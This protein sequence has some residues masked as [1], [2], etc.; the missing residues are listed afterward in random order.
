MTVAVGQRPTRKLT[1]S[2][3]GTCMGAAPLGIGALYEFPM[4]HLAEEAAVDV[5]LVGDSLGMVVLGHNSMVPVA[6]DATGRHTR[7]VV[8]GAPKIHVIADMPFLTNHVDDGGTS[9]GGGRL[10][11]EEGADPVKLE[12]RRTV[13]RRI[14]APVDAGIPVC[15]H[16]GVT[17]EGG[18][19][20]G[21]LRVEGAAAGRAPHVSED[22]EAVAEAEADALIL[23]AITAEPAVPVSE[24]VSMPTIGIGAGANRD[25]QELLTDDLVRIEE[26]FAPQFVKRSVDLAGVMRGAYAYAEG[27]RQPAPGAGAY[28]PSR[29]RGGPGSRRDAKRM[30]QGAPPAVTVVAEQREALDGQVPGLVPLAGA[31]HEGHASLTSGSAA[32]NSAT[33]VTVF[34]NPAQFAD[35]D[36]FARYPKSLELHTTGTSIHGATSFFS[37]AVEKMDPTEP[38]SGARSPVAAEVDG[39][40]L[41]DNFEL[42][43]GVAG[44]AS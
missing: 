25:G 30:G 21:V 12:G 17:P 8:R 29:S 24:R 4:V 32:E 43:S 3:V 2:A 44:W 6:L 36:A 22:A 38:I 13:V 9:E 23:E 26:R 7:A 11:Q 19:A 18:G 35:P 27:V 34:V 41:I 5:I 10:I 28:L 42:V 40:R 20:L 39:M 14:R 31:I 1:A 33:V 37:P 16:G 15:A